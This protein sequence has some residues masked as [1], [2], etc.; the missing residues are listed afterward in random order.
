MNT[1]YRQRL[2]CNVAVRA[3]C[4]ATSARAGLRSRAD[5][6][7][8]EARFFGDH[9]KLQT[10]DRGFGRVNRVTIVLFFLFF[11]RNAT[12][13]NQTFFCEHSVHVYPRCDISL[14]RGGE[15]PK[16]TDSRCEDNHHPLVGVMYVYTVRSNRVLPSPPATRTLR[17][18]ARTVFPRPPVVE[19]HFLS[20]A[21]LSARIYHSE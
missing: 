16:R 11:S 15:T 21:F 10:T 8:R 3:A 7:V 14:D 2:T 18:T 1:L 12:F 20:H 13:Q 4:S 6:S 19:R 5:I 17:E 9:V